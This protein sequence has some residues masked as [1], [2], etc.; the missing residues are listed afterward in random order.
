MVAATRSTEEWAASDSMPSEPVR[1]PVRSLS[2]VMPRAARTEKRA[3]A[4]LAAAGFSAV[5]G[6]V[7]MRVWWRGRGRRCGR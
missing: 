2:A 7:L 5:C 1:M 4:R 6:V 3:A